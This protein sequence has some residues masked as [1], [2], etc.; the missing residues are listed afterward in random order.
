MTVVKLDLI[1]LHRALIVFHC[2]F[3]LKH[4]LFLVSFLKHLSDGVPRQRG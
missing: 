2:S 3:V 4:D 1:V